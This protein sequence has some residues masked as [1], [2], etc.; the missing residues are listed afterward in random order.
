MVYLC[1]HILLIPV[2]AKVSDIGQDDCATFKKAIL[3]TRTKLKNKMMG[4]APPD[5]IRPVPP[6]VV[7]HARWVGR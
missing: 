3:A 4:F 6:G 7:V 2:I 1:P 5:W